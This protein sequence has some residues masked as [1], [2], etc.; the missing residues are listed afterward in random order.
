MATRMHQHTQ[1]EIQNLKNLGR[2]HCPFTRPLP[3]W[4]GGY[5]LLIPTRHSIGIG[6]CG[7]SISLHAANPSQGRW[8]RLSYCFILLIML[9]QRVRWLIT[10]SRN[11]IISCSRCRCNDGNN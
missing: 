8:P 2:G 3:Q 9:Q 11:K 7:A 6:P 4:G 10:T 1:L 5:P